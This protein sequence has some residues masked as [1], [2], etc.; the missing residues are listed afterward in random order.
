MPRLLRPGGVPVEA[1]EAVLG[2]P[3]AAP[4]APAASEERVPQ[5]APGLLETHYAPRTPLV[6]V[7]DDNP[8]RAQACLLAGVEAALREGQ[9]VGVL[10]LDEDRDDLPAGAVSERVGAWSDPG[11]SAERLFHAL[12]TLDRAGLD[13]RFARVLADPSTGLGRALAD[14]LT[15]AAARRD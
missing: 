4:P 15:R 14:R 7:S 1:I 10:L 9:R 2:E 12:R 11:T 13:V 5:V 3:L 8:A 6:V